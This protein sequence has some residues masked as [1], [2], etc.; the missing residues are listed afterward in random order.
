M[1]RRTFPNFIGDFVKLQERQDRI[2][3]VMRIIGYSPDKPYT[4]NVNDGT[5]NTVQIGNVDGTYGIKIVNNLGATIVFADGHITADGITTGSLDAGVV[6]VINLS[7]SIIVT[8]ELSANRISGGIL[9]CNL[10]TVSNLNAGSITVGTFLSPNDRFTTGSLSGIK[11][12]DGTITGAKIV[13]F[14]IQADN[15][16][17]NA[18]TSD[19]ISAGTITAVKIQADT[20]TTNEINYM[21]GSK[22]VNS[23][24]LATKI[25]SLNA[26]VV[27]TGTL[28]GRKVQTH[29]S[30]S[31]GVKMNTADYSSLSHG[32]L[33]FWDDFGDQGLIY[34]NRSRADF[35][36]E[37]GDLNIWSADLNM[38]GGSLQSTRR[39]DSDGGD[40]DL[41][42][43]SG[44]RVFFQDTTGGGGDLSMYPTWGDFYAT[45]TKHFRIPHPEDPEN[46]SIQYVSVEAPEVMLKIRG[47][48]KLKN[49]SATVALPH[50][51]ELVTEAEGIT[52]QL[53]AID[54]C[55]G[56]FVP[57]VGMRRDSFN[58]KELM[59]GDSNAEFMW[60][61]TAVR[62]G[63]ADFNPIQTL[64]DEAKRVVD[65]MVIE[66]EKGET[67]HQK[68]RKTVSG[69][70]KLKYKEKTGKVFVGDNEL[71]SNRLEKTR[72]A[73]VKKRKKQD[74][75]KRLFLVD[76][77]QFTEQLGYGIN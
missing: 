6:N 69:L 39:I 54:D 12:S 31:Y 36:I 17:T 9:N 71:E 76:N 62:K 43:G 2:E 66:K 26:D 68:R 3:M 63:Y 14:T 30:S 4:L 8:G 11:L 40:L 51:W 32:Y 29:S 56:L 15:I 33:E 22:L 27:T 64:E 7:A 52:V 70:V 25:A 38:R 23:S 48:A 61:V 50:H 37:G 77:L 65:G 16:A 13:A 21:S 47:K 49:G 46:K 60:E 34:Y 5:R 20:I 44:S 41:R 45:G 75:T 72:K 24:V 57:R 19:K 28:T 42:C 59:S 58:V 10:M 74:R 67:I 55:Y 53:T 73:H 1:R 35:N 18:I